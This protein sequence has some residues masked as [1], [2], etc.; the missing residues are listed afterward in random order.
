MSSS[1][2]PCPACPGSVRLT[3]WDMDNMIAE[4]LKSG[5]KPVDDHTYQSRLNVCSNC[6]SLVYETTCM[7]CGCIVQ[8]RALDSARKC[9]HPNGDRWRT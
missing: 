5:I 2:R 1:V 9:P 8:I 4:A 6:E 7:K 3:S